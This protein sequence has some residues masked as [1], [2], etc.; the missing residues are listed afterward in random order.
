MLN[1]N[2]SSLTFEFTT[3]HK[4]NLTTL[5]VVYRTHVFHIKWSRG[6]EIQIWTRLIRDRPILANVFINLRAVV[7]VCYAGC[8]A[9][10]RSSA[11]LAP[12]HFASLC[13][14]GDSELPTRPS[15]HDY[16]QM[17]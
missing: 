15:N 2:P 3:G 4:L 12:V 16:L 1:I 9:T 5:R 10:T 8:L 14:F 13:F 6:I 17:R 11:T 7:N